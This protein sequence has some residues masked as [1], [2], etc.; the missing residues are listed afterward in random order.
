MKSIDTVVEELLEKARRSE[1]RN[2]QKKFNYSVEISININYME[3]PSK[4]KYDVNVLL[5]VKDERIKM[6][7]GKF[8][9]V[10]ETEESV[11]AEVF[12]LKHYSENNNENELEIK[13]SES[14]SKKIEEHKKAG[15]I[16]G[17]LK[18]AISG[19][20]QREE[21][22]SE[23]ERV[24]NLIKNKLLPERIEYYNIK[25]CNPSISFRSSFEKTR[26]FLIEILNYFSK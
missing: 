11:G 16:L 13:E 5:G 17:M 4:E 15:G 6:F 10:E 26:N 22:I 19:L 8:Y 25:I 9:I 18:K 7:L 1:K 14:K 23:N 12:V 20:Y 24:I 3:V 2:A 21:K